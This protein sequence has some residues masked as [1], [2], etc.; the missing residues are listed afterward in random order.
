MNP[1]ILILYSGTALFWITF[2]FYYS[3]MIEFREALDN[4]FLIKW[5]MLLLPLLIISI[6]ILRNKF[7]NCEGGDK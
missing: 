7:A 4:F 3:T 2:L 6:D 1:R 5:A